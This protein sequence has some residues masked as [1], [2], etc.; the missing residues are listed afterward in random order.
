MMAGLNRKDRQLIGAVGFMEVVRMLGIFLILPVLEVYSASLT[1]SVI[2]IALAFGAY[3]LASAIFQSFFGILSDRIGRKAAII[4]GLIP[5]IAGN[6]LTFADHS[7]FML[8]LGRFIAG[9]GAIG[10]VAT[11]MVQENV[12]EE[13]RNAAMALVGIPVGIAFLIGL[14]LGPELGYAI[15]FYYLFLISAVLGIAAVG[16]VIPLKVSQTVAKHRLSGIYGINRIS[17]ALAIAGFSVSFFMI[18]FFYYFQVFATTVLLQDNYVL[19]IFIPGIVGGGIAVMIAGR[20]E[21]KRT[22][23][24]AVSSIAVILVSVPIL[25]LAPLQKGSLLIMETGSVVFFLGYSLY[26]I[27]FPTAITRFASRYH[28]GSNLGIFNTLQHVGQFAGGTASGIILGIQL[29]RGSQ[30]T[31]MII[32]LVL[33]GIAM[34]LSALVYTGSRTGRISVQA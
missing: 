10:S 31:A 26:E 2:L 33:M 8:I 32:L 20:F 18:L 27:V 16:A 19:P 34:A 3:G 29:N 23:I 13:K 1:S 5:F 7:I 12:P 4:I 11:A 30:F 25:F 17:V 9:A 14:L 22:T 6:L 21:G 24:M 15:G 28:Y